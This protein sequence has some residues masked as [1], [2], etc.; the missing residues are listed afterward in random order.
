MGGL[1]LDDRDITEL[2]SQ[3][4]LSLHNMQHLYLGRNRIGDLGI[5]HLGK[6]MVKG[7][8]RLRRLSVESN[9]ISHVGAK[10]LAGT[11]SQWTRQLREL[12]IVSGNTLDS[13]MT[14]GLTHLRKALTS[15]KKQRAFGIVQ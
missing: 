4:L 2:C 13:V 10:L 15:D 12:H 7:M 14:R 1:G 3:A 9:S 11:A 8:P 5:D 6:A